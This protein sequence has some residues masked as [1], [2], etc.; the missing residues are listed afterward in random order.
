MTFN[1]PEPGL[2]VDFATKLR[3]LRDVLLQDALLKTM[4]KLSIPDVDRE[5]AAVVPGHVLAILASNG[6]RGELVFPVPVVLK[7]NPRLVAY[8]RLLYGFSQKEF[9]RSDVAGPIRGAEER[10]VWPERHEGRVEEFCA[11]MAAS[12]A[13][14]MAGVAAGGAVSSAFLHDLSLLTLGPQWRGG[15]NVAIGAAGIVAVFGAVKEIV[16]N[17]IE[18]VDVTTVVVR[19]AAGRRV[20]IEL[21]P[22]PDIVIREEMSTGRFNLKIAIE[23]KGGRDFSNVHNRIGEAEKSHQKARLKGYVECWTVVNV[24]RI[25]VA[26]ARQESPST[27]RFFR[28]TDLIAATGPDYAD[29]RDGIVSLTGVLG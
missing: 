10:G 5:L 25:D 17:A 9:Y 18:S 1:I 28:I 4:A 21:A 13:L 14:L 26:M 7:A 27:N 23:V 15:S 2:Q 12:G 3:Q 8:Y 24:D 19:N 29:F 11:A 6:L 16:A 20:F 22:D